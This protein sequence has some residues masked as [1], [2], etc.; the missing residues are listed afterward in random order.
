MIWCRSAAGTASSIFSPTAR[1][2]A[3]IPLDDDI[4]LLRPEYERLLEAIA[5]DD[6]LVTGPCVPAWI[7]KVADSRIFYLSWL[8]CRLLEGR[9]RDEG[10]DGRRDRKGSLNGLSLNSLDPIPVNRPN[11][12]EISIE[13]AAFSVYC[14]NEI[15]SIII[16]AFNVEKYI[17]ETIECVL[18]QTYQDWELEI[19]DDCST[20]STAAIIRQYAERDSRIHLWTLEKNVGPGAARNNSVKL[21]RGRYLAFLDS[22]DWWYPDKLEKQMKFMTESGYEFT[23]TA[24]EYADKNLNVTGV[25]HKPRYISS[26]RMKIGDNIGTPGAIYDTQRIGKIYMPNMRT[27]E[28]WALFIKISTLTNGAYSLNIPLWKYRKLQES[29]SSNK[30]DLVK[31]NVRMYRNVLGYSYPKAVAI[32]LFGFMPNHII[33]VIYNKIDSFF[34]LRKYHSHAPERA[35]W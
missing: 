30:W 15:V 27:S 23:F 16:S 10:G 26:F 18:A 24:F 2:P 25:S 31:S 28:D 8:F 13:A 17:A 12:W 4:V 7:A 1:C 5:A 29:A 6:D 21:A 33:K 20:D 35:H 34:Y 11:Q 3:F 22:D 19:T 14:M 32:F 9:P